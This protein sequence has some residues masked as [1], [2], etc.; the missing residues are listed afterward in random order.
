MLEMEKKGINLITLQTGRIQTIQ[1][2]TPHHYDY[3]RNGKGRNIHWQTSFFRTPSLEPRWLYTTH[4]EGNAQA[5]TKNHGTP[6]QVVLMYAASHYPTWRQELG[7]PEIGPGGFGENFTVEGF[8]EENVSIGDVFVLGAT[9]GETLVQVTGPRY[10][11]SKIERRWKHEGLTA[12]V[13]ATGRTGW[14]CRVLQEGRVEPGMSLEQI[15][16][17]YP[18]FTMALINGYGHGRLKEPTLAHRLAD[19]PLMDE[20]WQELVVRWLD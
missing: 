1:V 3:R 11:C 6:G 13:A 16:R 19:C 10:P 5:D 17:P 18:D 8:N 4:L 7:K 20:F 2:G 12:R 14:Y 9:G 15:E